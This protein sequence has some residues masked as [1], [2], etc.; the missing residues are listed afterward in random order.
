MRGQKQNK[1]DVR[2]VKCLRSMREVSTLETVGKGKVRHRVGKKLFMIER[3][4]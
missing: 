3:E 2:E 4:V 1:F